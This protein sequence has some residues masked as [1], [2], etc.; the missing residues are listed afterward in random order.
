MITLQNINDQVDKYNEKVKSGNF[1]NFTLAREKKE[2]DALKREFK[3]QNLKLIGHLD[4]KKGDNESK[5]KLKAFR[6][7]RR[8]YLP[9]AQDILEEHGVIPKQSVAEALNSGRFLE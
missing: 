2:L 3:R 1:K 8:V 6:F 9:E 5:V 4:L 7:H